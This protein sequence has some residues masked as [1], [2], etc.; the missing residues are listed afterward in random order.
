MRRWFKIC[1]SRIDAAAGNCTLTADHVVLQSRHLS[2]YSQTAR[3]TL[4]L[5]YSHWQP[6]GLL[7][8]AKRTGFILDSPIFHLLSLSGEIGTHC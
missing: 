8:D 2:R 7:A 5:P 3:G 1:N 4:K 6:V